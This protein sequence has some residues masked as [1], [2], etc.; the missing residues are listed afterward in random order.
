MSY[1][2]KIGEIIVATK[3][4][5]RT[6]TGVDMNWL[7]CDQLTTDHWSVGQWSVGRSTDN[8]YLLT[9]KTKQFAVKDEI[10]L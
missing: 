8:S 9:G 7:Y 4:R 1:S 3:H 5:A 6:R 2:F 10:M